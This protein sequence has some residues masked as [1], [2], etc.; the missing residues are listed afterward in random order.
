[1]LYCTKC[2]TLSPDS[3]RTCPNCKRSRALR[4][5][6]EEDEVFFLKV[7][8]VE[9]A[10]LELLF[11]EQAVRH[12]AQPVRGGLAAGVYDPE[13]M[14]TDR[15]LY[16]A[17][18]DLERANALVAAEAEPKEPS[19]EPDEMPGGKRMVIQTVSILA[20]LLLVTAVVLGTDALASWVRAL[21]G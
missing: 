15:E 8:E 4:P 7:S 16:V 18:G 13:Y 5:V 1:M 3:T 19:P 6:R 12:R 9:A 2:R 14:P 11:E 17:Y 21:F 10:E 20:F